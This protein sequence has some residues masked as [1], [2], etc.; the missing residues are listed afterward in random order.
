MR[1]LTAVILTVVLL[2]FAGCGAHV[3]DEPRVADFSFI[4]P[5]GASFT[6]VTDTTAS[7]VMDGRAVGGITL[8]DI[9]GKSM[10]KLDDDSLFRYID[11]CAPMPLIGEWIS[12][13]FEEDGYKYVYS[14]VDLENNYAKVI[15]QKVE[16]GKII[17]DKVEIISGLNQNSLIVVSNFNQ[18]KLNKKNRIK[19]E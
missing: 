18:I 1:R 10:E 17:D 5:P 14:V 12:M 3:P 15:K 16:V 9:E 7:I 4:L 13:F 19:Y 2:L 8:T 6:D 11:S